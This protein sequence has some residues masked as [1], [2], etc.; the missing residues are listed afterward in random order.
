MFNNIAKALLESKAVHLEPNNFFTWTSGI[1]SPIYCDNRKLISFPVAR[2]EIVSGFVAK[3]KELY[4]ECESIAGTATAGIPWAA[5][6]ANEM[7]LPM[8]Y[9][10]SKAKAHGTKSAIEGAPQENQKI[11]IIE[12]LISTGKS[13]IAA[14]DEVKKD[15]LNLLGVISI[16]TYGLEIAKNKFAKAGIDYHS[17]CSLSELLKYAGE[18]S[19]LSNSEIEIIEKW[20][21]SI[22]I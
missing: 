5:W 19:L 6:I 2:K 10:R 1:K 13:S 15:N 17:L 7:N 4:P 20:R 9:I 22:E 16:F 3:I 14:A 18:K 12:D 21:Q 11:V 8:L